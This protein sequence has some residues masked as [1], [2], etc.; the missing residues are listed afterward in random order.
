MS[1]AGIAM[2]AATY[3]PRPYSEPPKRKPSGPRKPGMFS[4]IKNKIK[5]GWKAIKRKPKPEVPYYADKNW[6]PHKRLW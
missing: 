2:I 5:R 4:R 3:K 1:A 6:V